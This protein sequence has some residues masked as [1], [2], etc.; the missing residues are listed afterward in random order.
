MSN[1]IKS[2]IEV[3]CPECG[4]GLGMKCFQ[5]K[6]IKRGATHRRDVKPHSARKQAAK[7]A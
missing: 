3:R 6:R 5:Q 4:A 1:I 7:Q 2:P